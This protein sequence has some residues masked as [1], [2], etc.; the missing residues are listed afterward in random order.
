MSQ[1]I[2]ILDS[3]KITNNIKF[4]DE[5]SLSISI[6]ICASFYKVS[7]CLPKDYILYCFKKFHSSFF[8]IKKLYTCSGLIYH[9][10]RYLLQLY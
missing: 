9:L 10:L 6:Y 8:R 5:L 1:E 2:E 4:T 3:E 7:A